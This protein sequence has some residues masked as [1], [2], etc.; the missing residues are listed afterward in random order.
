MPDTPDFPLASFLGLTVDRPE[1]GVA[2]ARLTAGNAHVN[3]H[4]VVHGA[5]LFALVD[6]AMGAATY[7][8]MPEGAICAS[9]E[10][11]LRFLSPAT[12]GAELAA[13]VRV[14]KAGSRIVHLDARVHADGALVATAAGSFAV[15]TPR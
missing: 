6:T 7:S 14:V 2:A 10:V 4:G 11:Q 13:D 15:F 12:I 8:V 5:V 9:I 1:G 3:P